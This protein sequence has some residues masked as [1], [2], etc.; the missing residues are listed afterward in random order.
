MCKNYA[1]LLIISAAVLASCSEEKEKKEPAPVTT[2]QLNVTY[3]GAPVSGIPVTL[4]KT[5]QHWQTEQN[6]VQT[7]ITSANGKAFFSYLTEAE[8]YVNAVSGNLSNWGGVILYSGLM[9]N[10]G[11]QAAVQLNNHKGKL[12]SAAAGKLWHVVRYKENDVE[13]IDDSTKRCITDNTW[14][15]YKGGQ[16]G[17]FTLN[18][19][20]TKCDS[21]D[22]QLLTGN[23]V[24]PPDGQSLAITQNQ[25]TQT[26]Q[27]EYLSETTIR[28]FAY[29]N[30]T[31]YAY[32][33]QT[34]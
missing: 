28:I 2:L 6:P 8:Y 26:W 15:F 1:F 14:I 3:G 24:F 19:G 20:P 16:I 4:Y 25:Q 23:W 13:L 27:L 17:D 7:A 5:R 32:T 31:K 29:I 18:E 30:G 21:A 11:N 33:L 22:A 34:I 9:E 10:S 12:L